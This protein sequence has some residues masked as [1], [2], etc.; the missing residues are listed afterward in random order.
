[1]RGRMQVLGDIENECLQ[2]LT[3]CLTPPFFSFLRGLRKLP[4]LS[5]MNFL[6]FCVGLKR[7]LWPRA[8]S[9]SQTLLWQ[10]MRKV[11]LAVH[12]FLRNAFISSRTTI[13]LYFCAHFILLVK[14][15]KVK[16]V[17]LW[18][19]R[20]TPEQSVQPCNPQHFTKCCSCILLAW[21]GG[22]DEG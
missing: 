21:E 15:V 13:F 4:F 2:C 19:E 14:Q 16:R 3:A 8:A 12:G 5:K 7:P 11:Y 20:I 22:R 1:M 6:R 17:S 9:R 10:A 18:S